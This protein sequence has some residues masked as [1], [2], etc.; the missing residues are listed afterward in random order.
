MVKRKHKKPKTKFE[1]VIQW[2][3]RRQSF[4]WK[5]FIS[6]MGCTYPCAETNYLSMLVSAGYIN[7]IATGLYENQITSSGILLSKLKSE[8]YDNA[9]G[10]KVG[11]DDGRPD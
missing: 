7:K 6:S 4:R 5:E 2:V 11:L 1:K 8:A 10:Y 9:P 3:N